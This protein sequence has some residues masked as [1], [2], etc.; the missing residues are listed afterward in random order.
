MPF[1]VRT[2]MSPIRNTRRITRLTLRG[3]GNRYYAFRNISRLKTLKRWNWLFNVFAVVGAFAFSLAVT[4]LLVW[5]VLA[6]I[7]IL[8]KSDWLA[9]MY[10]YSTHGF[11]IGAGLLVGSIVLRVC[12]EFFY[13]SAERIELKRIP[14]GSQ[15]YIDVMRANTRVDL[16][17][18]LM[19]LVIVAAVTV[20]FI[21][22]GVV[23]IGIAIGVVIVALIVGRLLQNRTYD[24]V[25][26]QIVEI[27]NER[28]ANK[29]TN[30]E[31]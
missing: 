8:N 4:A 17:G 26:T 12:F 7:P 1:F 16:Y 15:K 5:F 20:A 23:A 25:G 19:W 21:I 13:S 29:S 28:R 11:V 24:R 2:L 14:E 3:R 6:L 31:H 9:D 18:I 27:K 10:W 30:T 22:K